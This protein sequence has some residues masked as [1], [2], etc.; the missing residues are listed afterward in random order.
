MI[1]SNFHTH[2][3]FCDGMDS[4]EELVLC[5]IEQGCAEIGFSGHS[6]VEFDKECCMSISGTEE[7]KKEIVGL[8]E[9][10]ADKI[11]ILL[12][13]EQDIYSEQ[14]TEDYDYII[15]SVHYILKDNEYLFVDFSRQRQIDDVNKHYG[16]DFYAYIEDYY[17]LVGELYEK[18][19]CDII[20][21]FDLITKFNEKGDLFDT[22][23]PR[24]I[25]AV[26]GAL[27]HLERTPVIFEINTGAISRGYRSEAYPSDFIR[28][29]VAELARP[30]VI[31]SDAHSAQT[32][33]FGIEKEIVMLEDRGYK[34][35]TSLYDFLK[36]TKK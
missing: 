26:E 11:K 3:S 15:G 13:V 9:K 24:Y 32:L 2:T 5:A 27:K 7:Y 1:L 23:H 21:H 4:A 14:S 8:R 29:K 18:T 16:G 19:G 28:A 34:Y 25:K 10:Y 17:K 31:N 20:G 6:F 22:G 12:G 35:I 30:F 36:Q 33:F